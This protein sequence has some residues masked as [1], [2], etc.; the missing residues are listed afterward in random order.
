MKKHHLKILFPRSELGHFIEFEKL[1]F[2]WQE[3]IENPVNVEEIPKIQIVESLQN[4]SFIENVVE[5][6]IQYLK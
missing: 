5:V 1:L 2:K 4:N 6:S 3:N